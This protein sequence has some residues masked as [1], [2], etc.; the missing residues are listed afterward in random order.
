MQTYRV[1]FPSDYEAAVSHMDS[2]ATAE[3]DE[4]EPEDTTDYDAAWEAREEARD[5]KYSR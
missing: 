3:P 5:R 2:L 1:S 4:D